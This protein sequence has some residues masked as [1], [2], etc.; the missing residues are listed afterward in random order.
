MGSALLI[1]PIGVG[2][3]CTLSKS[4]HIVFI[5]SL[6]NLS[7]PVGSLA[8]LAS[9]A[10]AS[11]STAKP[12]SQGQYSPAPQA[13]DGI[14]APKTF[15][16]G[17]AKLLTASSASNASDALAEAGGFSC[18]DCVPGEPCP[19]DAVGGQAFND[20]P[21]G[22]TGVISGKDNGDG[23]WDWIIRLHHGG[24]VI[25]TCEIC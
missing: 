11:Y 4:E 14:S 24:E 18:E 20:P 2:V 15:A 21:G 7:V 5:M 17:Y 8:L 13:C 23:T 9:L 19:M 22:P 10:L 12:Q 16:P 1:T 3:P 25:I 6:F